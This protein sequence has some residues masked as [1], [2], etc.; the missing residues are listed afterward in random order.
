MAEKPDGKSR[1]VERIVIPPKD[2]IDALDQ[3]LRQWYMYASEFARIDLEDR[4]DIEALEYMKCKEI[5]K[6][7]KA[8]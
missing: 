8:V 2:L 6:K 1:Q 3:V 4:N 5:L 7:Y